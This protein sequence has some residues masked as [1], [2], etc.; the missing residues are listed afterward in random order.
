MLIPTETLSWLPARRA[1]SSVLIVEN[2]SSSLIMSLP[3]QET[4][5]LFQFSAYPLRQSLERL[6]LQPP[7]LSQ[8]EDQF[9]SFIPGPPP[10]AQARPPR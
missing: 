10:A 6:T 1:Y 9:R 3:W 8:P 7:P 5:H 2:S 4:E